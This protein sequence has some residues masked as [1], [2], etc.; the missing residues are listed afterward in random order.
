MFKKILI[1]N[2]GEIACRIIRT[3]GS[4][5]IASVAVYSE[6]DVESLHVRLADEAVCVGPAPA[7]ESYLSAAN[8]LD[9][10]RSTG[11]DA[12]HPGYGFMSEN[13][14]FAEACAEAGIA[15][16]GPTPA[17]MREFGLKH[18]ARELARRA[19][20]PLLPGTG[21][22]DSVA[23]AL[24]AAQEIGYPVMLKSTAGGGGIGMRL[25]ADA[26]EL[27]GA[28]TSVKHLSENNFKNAGIYLEKFVQNARHVEVQ[29]FGD[30]R[31]GVVAL[32][33]R[34]CSVQRRNQKVVEETP[35]PC[36]DD[37]TRRALAGTAVRL[38]KSIDY[39]SAGTV[40][41]VLDADS[42][43]FY[44]LEVNTRLQVE[45]GV[46]EAV[47]GVDLVEWMIRAATGAAD[48]FALPPQDTLR[49]EGHAMQLRVYA[50]DPAKNFQPSSG[51]LTA[52][53]FADGLR[54]DTW[55][56]RGVT[57][58]PYYDPLLA[59]LIVHTPSR[60]ASIAALSAALKTTSIAGI[61]TNLAYLSAIL[62]YPA[63]ASGRQ[64]T[65]M[66]AS[67]PYRPR[68]VEVL[69]GGIQTTIQDYPGRL[70]LWAV[71]IPPSGPMDAYAHRYANHLLG[72]EE[73]A[74]T[75]EMTLQGAVLAFNCD[76]MIALAGAD[77][78]ATVSGPDGKRRLAPWQAHRIAAGETLRFSSVSGAG[79]R[80]YLA[81]AGGIDA[82]QYLGSRATF[83]LG[84]FGGHGGRALRSGDVLRLNVADDIVPRTAPAVTVPQYGHAWDIAVHYGP[85]GA[86]DFFT[87]DDIAM[88]F[89]TDWQVHF[90]SSR[91]GVRLSGPKPRWARADGGEA[92]LHPSNIHDNAYAIGS[93]DF[94]GD[95]PV[96]LGPDG[97]SLGG[98]VC[99]AVIVSADLWKMGQLKPG[100]TVRFIRVT[101]EEAAA[102][103]SAQENVFAADGTARTPPTFA[104]LRSA[105]GDAQLAI[106][107]RSALP[108]GVEV[109]YRRAGDD[110]LLIEFGELVL[111][112]NLRFRVHA[113]MRAIEEATLEGV[114]DLTPGIRS[115]Q[116][117]FDHRRLSG[118]RLAATVDA[119]IAGLKSVED[120][121]VASRIVHLPLAWNDTQTRLAIQKYQTTVRPD[122]PWCPSNIEFIRRING[123]DSVQDVYDVLFNASYMVLGLGDVYLGAPVATPIDPRH[124]LVTTKYN[125]ARTW[126]PENA[127]GI[128]GAYL[129]VYGMEGPGGYQFVGRTVQMWNRYRQ[130]ESF[131]DGKPW[132]LR[133]F[134]QIRFY[135]VSEEQLLEH[136]RDFPLG[137]FD[138]KIEET[139]F[140]LAD[141]NRFLAA[142]A[143]PISAFKQKQQAAFE[144][145]RERWQRS[146]Q[147]QWV[148]E[149]AVSNG[150]AQADLPPGSQHLSAV[151]PGSV[152]KV[153]VKPGDAIAEGDTIAILESMKME[154]PL[155]ATSAGV[156]VEWLVGE[157]T[158]V[159]AGQHIAVFREAREDEEGTALLQS[160][161]AV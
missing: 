38:A 153:M 39:L 132:L 83:T 24:A 111:D 108:D 21:L 109:V 63:F 66:L 60:G 23:Q 144:A 100:D 80:A 117:H 57:V 2:R 137:R 4:M 143:G 65:R 72:N 11:A 82:P 118:T 122:A 92:G 140:S 126:T 161:Q 155:T 131:R 124:R 20:V 105:A 22:L 96:I 19:E 127:V 18:T 148:S 154:I 99:P 55:V 130:T 134:D 54:V 59:K 10:A 158:P 42:G 46:T 64:T 115:L 50:E 123:L 147:A 16:I 71:G 107:G 56:E 151:V 35:A 25:C 85:H 36:L 14:G 157:G 97:P 47:F 135:E 121:T 138:V 104:P 73:S 76:S 98:F 8:V 7:A 90:N 51:V 125:P 89:G 146:G 41:Y 88:F 136:R 6:A 94:T 120:M 27:E 74:A 68:T 110:Y 17:Q 152:W 75:L 160:S 15:F 13:A 102:L 43:A 3:A 150:G 128:G 114:I 1:A 91:T 37:E 149:E 119:L 87:D 133:F 79:V 129:C 113:L 86:P 12:I 62:G 112:I 67:M 70:G 103:R 95:M 93:V 49:P 31:G 29:I 26:Q 156:L 5:G 77:L 141:Y 40:E 30:G 44:F 48:E 101:A 52:V 45:H 142:Q 9:A 34:D 58:S 145:E 33:E 61:E 81:F 116:V 28:Y 139:T 159:A 69:E 32:G 106:L 53:E 78:G 84:N